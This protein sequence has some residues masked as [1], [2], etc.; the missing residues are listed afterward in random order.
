MNGVL[1]HSSRF[2]LCLQIIDLGG[3]IESEKHH[4]LLDCRINY[5]CKRFYGIGQ[6]ELLPSALCYC[7]TGWYWCQPSVSC[8][9][10]NHQKCFDL[11][12]ASSNSS[13]NIGFMPGKILA[14]KTKPGGC[15]C[16]THFYCYEAK[17]PNLK[18]KTLPEQLLGELL[19]C[20]AP[21]ARD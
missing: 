11:N 13:K 8:N 2:Q 16:V 6:N 3:V 10:P 19:L 17:L 21:R 15:V 12:S 1:L 14:N 5:D 20:H 9:V 4:R 18:L 7:N